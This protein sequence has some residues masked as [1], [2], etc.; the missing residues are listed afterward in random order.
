MSLHSLSLSDWQIK[1]WDF[2]PMGLDP[3]K[4]FSMYC[5]CESK[6]EL[7]VQFIWT[8]KKNNPVSMVDGWICCWWLGL[9]LYLLSIQKFK[10]HILVWS[11]VDGWIPRWWLDLSLMV[12][13]VVIFVI[14]SGIQMS[15]S[16]LVCRWWCPLRICLL[17]IYV[18]KLNVTL[19]LCLLL[20]VD[21]WWLMIP[22]EDL[23]A[24]PFHGTALAPP[25][26][27]VNLQPST[28]NQMPTS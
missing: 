9:S 6:C 24:L 13:S 4:P 5:L 20:M 21:G 11:V 16:G 2:F 22:T 23:S 25:Q 10:C 1:N 14:Y 8:Y 17:S 28:N 12:G 3:S 7:K 19:W 26:S 27:R 18:E 15:H